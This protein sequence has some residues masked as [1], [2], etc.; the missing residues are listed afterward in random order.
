MVGWDEGGRD[1]EDWDLVTVWTR[2]GPSQPELVAHGR[3]PEGLSPVAIVWQTHLSVE[4]YEAGGRALEVP[5][6]PCP[7]CGAPMRYSGWY[8]RHARAGASRRLWARRQL[9]KFR[10]V[11]HAVLPSF[12]TH[13]RLDAVGVMGAEL[14]VM[15]GSGGTTAGTARALGLPRS[16]LR[17][18]RRRFAERGSVGGSAQALRGSGRQPLALH[19]RHGRRP[20]AQH[21][22]DPPW[23][24]TFLGRRRQVRSADEYRP[25]T[26]TEWA[27]FEE[28][29]DRRK[30]ELGG[31]ARPYGTPCQAFPSAQLLA[32][33]TS[34]A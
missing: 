11:S 21:H 22:I 13:G 24:T 3:G 33:P 10:G 28:H 1:W 9:C 4:S 6:F 16:T 7:T 20:P 31:C 19:Q 27:G 5:R 25:V 34:P 8:R 29:F 15:A 12:V 17:A 32:L 23:K 2:Q 14:E 30:V 18:W 26:G